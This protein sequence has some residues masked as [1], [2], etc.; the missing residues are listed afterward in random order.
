[1]LLAINYRYVVWQEQLRSRAVLDSRCHLALQV[2]IYC[3]IKN[4]RK[5]TMLSV[6][7]WDIFYNLFLSVEILCKQ[8]LSQVYFCLIKR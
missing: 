3:T 6:T 5:V 4:V 2:E 1:M 8:R 7:V